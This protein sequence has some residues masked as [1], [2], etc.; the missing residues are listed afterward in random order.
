MF[1]NSERHRLHEGE[2]HALRTPQP[3]D[4]AGVL[5]VRVEVR[6]DHGQGLPDD[7]AAVHR[8]PVLGAQREPRG[9]EVDQFG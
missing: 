3:T 1:Q 6:E 7:P 2:Q 4:E 5:A 8:H 9:L